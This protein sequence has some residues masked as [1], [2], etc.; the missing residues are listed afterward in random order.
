[1]SK[2]ATSEP[3]VVI[4]GGGSTGLMLAGELA[5]AGIEVV[6]LE[7]RPNQNL[8]GARA[9]GISARTIEVLDQRGIAERFLAAGQ[10]AQ[11]TG[12]ATT[13]LDI[14][15]FPTRHNYGLALA[16]KHIEHLLAEWAQELGVATWYDHEVIGFDQDD[17]GVHVALANGTSLH[18]QYLVGCDG[19]RSFVRKHAGI[20]FPG[21][22]ATTSSILA[23]V[24]MTETPPY[25]VHRSA[26]GMYAFGRSEYELKG[27]EIIYKDIGPIRVMVTEPDATAT[28]VPTLEDLRQRLVATCGTDY[29]VHTP[30]WLSRFTDATR[31]A[32]TYRRGRVLLAGDAAHTHSPI[33]GQGLGL[34][35]QDAMNLGWKLAQVVRGTSPHTL[36]DSYHDER[37]P[38]GAMVLKMT[39]AQ[40]AMLRE[41]ARAVAARD[42]VGDLLKMD[43]P[44]RHVAGLMSGLSIRYDFGNGHPLLGHRLPDLDL[45]TA[46][47]PRRA[48]ALLHGARPVFII[49]DTADKLDIEPWADRVQYI[50]ATY[51][52]R[53]ELPV[54]GSVPPPNAVLVRP[55]GHV[56]WVGDGTAR[57]LHEALTR[58]CGAPL[59]GESR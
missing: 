52:G 25:G 8:A 37:H 59:A 53:W 20:D 44:R 42:V 17:G 2:P 58:W 49:F 28:G 46:H 23:E 29:G 50:G 41:D 14:S 1:M 45:V 27:G 26:S 56:A 35:I 11:I 19:G 39:M 6:V 13:R 4:V 40:V 55:D 5:L 36:L 43:E 3:A 32:A 7:R 30:T 54:I 18:T 51:T 22:N 15:D 16:Q 47:G 57:G 10:P 48:Y 33:G 38:V 9:L 34:G 12:F 21:W 31:Q 24:E